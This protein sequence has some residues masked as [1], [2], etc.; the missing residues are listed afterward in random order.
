MKTRRWVNCCCVGH[1]Q[2]EILTKSNQNKTIRKQQQQK[3]RTKKS[4]ITAMDSP[5]K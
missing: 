3:Q 5:L 1:V 2:G 4:T